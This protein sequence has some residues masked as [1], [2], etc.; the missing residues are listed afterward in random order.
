MQDIGVVLSAHL[1][2]G[3]G[4]R[5]GG[6]RNKRNGLE[7]KETRFFVLSLPLIDAKQPCALK[8]KV[9]GPALDMDV[10]TNST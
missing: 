5:G 6:G 2:L 4:A 10:R 9:D 8:R 3:G 7:K 1:N